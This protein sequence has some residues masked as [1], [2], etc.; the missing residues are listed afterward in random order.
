MPGWRRDSSSEELL[1]ADPLLFAISSRVSQMRG[2]GG[3]GVG[4]TS[5]GG[6]DPTPLWYS[7]T[8]RASTGGR[9][10]GG[11]GLSVGMEL[12]HVPFEA[13]T[14][15]QPIGAGSFGQVRWGG[16]G[17]GLSELAPC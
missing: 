17:E 16:Q 1:A 13:L 5:S 4:S 2:G 14:F 6:S 12:W 10:P 9:Q 3:G 7:S 11:S 8:A 15:L